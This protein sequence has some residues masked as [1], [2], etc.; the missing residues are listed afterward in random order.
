[1][2]GQ[3]A[4]GL[5]L[6]AAAGVVAV[7]G[8]VRLRRIWRLITAAATRLGRRR[9]PPPRPLGR[10]IE[11][12]ARD[13][14]R[15]GLRFRYVPAGASFAKF[16]GRRLAYDDVLA[17]ACRSLGIEHLLKVL[18]PGPELDIERLRVEAVL[19]RAGLRLDDVA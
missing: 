15:L 2:G 16:E 11:L 9:P 12:I 8:P 1:M 7:L 17:E 6:C 19:E 5:A 14:Q 18:P 3:P 10:P 13:A 4:E